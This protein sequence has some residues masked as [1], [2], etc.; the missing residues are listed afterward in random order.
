ML[1]VRGATGCSAADVS[2]VCGAS[3]GFR[4]ALLKVFPEELLLCP[5]LQ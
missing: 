5:L 4:A 1:H 2:V 3:E